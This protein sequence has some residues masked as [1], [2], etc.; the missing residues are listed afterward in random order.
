MTGKAER[1]GRDTAALRLA[2]AP[3]GPRVRRFWHGGDAGVRLASLLVFV[4]LWHV[5]AV[6]LQ[7]N[8]LPLPLTVFGRVVDETLSLA[9]PYHLGITLTRV[10]IAFAAAMV[11]GTVIGIAMGH[12][13]KLDLFLDGW[14]VLG[15]N[16]PALVTIILCYVWFGL[17]DTAAIIAVA[18]N[19]IPTVIVTVREG[20]RA[21]DPR[22]MQVA[23]AY[24]LPRWRTLSR[25]YL[26]QLY[27]YLMAAARTGLS[28]IWKIVLVVELLGRSNGIGFQLN[29]FFQ[30]FDIAGILAYTLVFAAIVLVVEAFVLRPLER[31][32][33][34]W[35]G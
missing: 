33:T 23:S 24:R 11:I 34:R 9:M 31:R 22:L 14:L 20:A 35:R 27:P 2:A 5:L 30:F 25:V 13:R 8:S 16:V 10:V 21:V 6:V 28:L 12:W 1:A 15:L 32:L 18:I 19:K 3:V 7:S 29:V 17:N 26:P 4:V